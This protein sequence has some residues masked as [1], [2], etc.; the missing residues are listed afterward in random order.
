MI[1]SFWI[2]APVVFTPSLSDI[3]LTLTVPNVHSL[4]RGHRPRLLEPVTSLWPH[5][6]LWFWNWLWNT[7]ISSVYHCDICHLGYCTFPGVSDTPSLICMK[8]KGG[9]SAVLTTQDNMRSCRVWIITKEHGEMVV[10][11]AGYKSLYGRLWKNVGNCSWDAWQSYGEIALSE[12]N[13]NIV[14][15]WRVVRVVKN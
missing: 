2:C 4:I 15:S 11:L 3:C 14:L 5:H 7:V 12:Q 13:R 8:H 9:V 1:S 6:F 10:T